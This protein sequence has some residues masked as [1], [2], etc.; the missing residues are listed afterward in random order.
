MAETRVKVV[1]AQGGRLAV[2]RLQR[3]TD[4][5]TG[6]IEATRQAGFERAC[7]QL[8]IGSLRSAEISWTR[9]SAK[10]KRGSER[11]PPYHIDGPIE[12]ISGQANICLSDP[13]RPVFHVHAVLTDPEGKAWGGHFFQGGNPVHATVDVVLQ[14]IN[15]AQM[16]WTY[17]EELDFELPVAFAK[18]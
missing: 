7:T 2:V 16:R 1:A 4:L 11:T 18:E 9:A 15:G 13:D 6:L 12:L 17:D 14:E 5:V 10:S 8:M 3:D